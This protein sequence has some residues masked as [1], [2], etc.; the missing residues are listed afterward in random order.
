MHYKLRNLVT[1]RGQKF[2]N[3]IILSRKVALRGQ[4]FIKKVNLGRKV[5]LPDFQSLDFILF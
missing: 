2:M 3:K 4:K 1:L 5:A